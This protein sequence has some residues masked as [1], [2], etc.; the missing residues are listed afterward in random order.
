M[1]L[2]SILLQENCANFCRNLMVVAHPDDESLWGAAHLMSGDWFIICLTNGDNK[3]RSKEFHKVLEYTHN[4]GIILTY[5]DLING[6]K[7]DWSECKQEII[8]DLSCALDYKEWEIIA[9]HNPE[10]ETGH[11]H[12]LNTNQYIFDLCKEK[13]LL[14]HL[15]YFGRFYEA[16]KIPGNLMRLPDSSILFKRKVVAL[17]INEAAPIKYFWA[18]MIPYENWVL[19]TSWGENE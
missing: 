8:S 16:E 3:V 11:I 9:T 19:S 4:Y 7:S 10:G 13:D 14:N 17:Y 1:Q 2:S 5:P 12:H 15:Y 6:I 18:Q